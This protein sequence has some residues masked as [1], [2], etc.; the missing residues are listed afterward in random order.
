MRDTTSNS[1]TAVADETVARDL[2]GMK[3][4]EE[5]P[6]EGLRHGKAQG[7]A[8]ADALNFMVTEVAQ[9]GAET[10]VGDYLVS[11]AVEEAEGMYQRT[12]NGSLEFQE[13]DEENLHVEVGVRDADDGRFVPGL[14]IEATLIDADGNEV[15]T[16]KQPFVWHPWIHHYGRNWTVPGP[17]RYDLRVRIAAPDFPRHDEE[18]GNRYAEAVTVEFKGIDIETGQD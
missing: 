13:P 5:A 12:S 1:A 8:L 7:Q 14:D 17:G 16:H 10:R 6:P 18:N 2:P 15:G 9:T 4:S 11:F 3:A